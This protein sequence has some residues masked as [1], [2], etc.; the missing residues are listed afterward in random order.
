METFEITTYCFTFCQS[1]QMRFL[2]FQVLLL[3]MASYQASIYINL[4]IPYFQQKLFK[5]L[6]EKILLQCGELFNPVCD[7]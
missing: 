3:A 6:M 1:F 7:Q 2:P 4:N 5:C